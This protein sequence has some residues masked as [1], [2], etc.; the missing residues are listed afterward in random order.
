M[1]LNEKRN[2]SLLAPHFLA[3]GFVS[4]FP[5]LLSHASALPQ[6]E[7]LAD[8]LLDFPEPAELEKWLQRTQD[9]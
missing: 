6:L 5:R 9:Q 8:A 3:L 7:A 4:R 1:V 2:K